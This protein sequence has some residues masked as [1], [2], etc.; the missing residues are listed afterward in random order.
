MDRQGGCRRLL[1][2]SREMAVA[3]GF[4]GIYFI[5]MKWPEDDC[6]P[7][8]IQMYKDFGFD[9]TGIYHFMSHGGVCP[10]N[11]RFPYSAVADANPANW[12]KQH[13]ANVLPFLPNLSTGWDDRPWNDHCEIHGKNA[14]DFR[15]ICAEAKKFADQ[16]GIKRLCLAPLNEWGEGSYA[17]PNT[18]HGFGFYEAV[19]D[20]FC[21]K[22]AAGWPL[23]W[24]MTTEPTI[25]PRP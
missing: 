16:T 14:A 2:I 15:R 21:R 7:K 17:E 11:R 13:E 1:E 9:M 24:V 4:K 20:T 18:E 8:T 22:P 10:T 12:W 25:K 5:A 23:N 6:R 19:R 3:A